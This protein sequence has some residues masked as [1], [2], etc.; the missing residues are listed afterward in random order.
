MHILRELFLY[1]AQTVPGMVYSDAGAATLD[2]Y[3]LAQVLK[4]STADFD[5]QV[6]PVEIV[7]GSFDQYAAVPGKQT[8]KMQLNFAMNAQ[9]GSYSQTAPQWTKVLTGSCNFVGAQTVA[10]T[11]P[12]VF[13]YTPGVA[14]STCGILDHYMGDQAASAAPKKRF[15]NVNGNFKISGQAN[16]VPE[17]QFTLDGSFYGEA[18]STQPDT[19]YA[20][21]RVSPTAFKGATICVGG[22]SALKVSKFEIEA[23]QTIAGR[24][25][26][27]E[28]NGSGYTDI[29]D[30]KIKW[31][32]TAYAATN[33][34]A[35]ILYAITAATEGALT[36]QW[37]PSGHDIQLL[38][39]Y[40]Q[41]TVRKRGDLSGIS[42]FE[43]EG[44]CNRND[45]QIGIGV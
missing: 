15:Y 36:L 6:D 31:K 16:K 34:L 38:S 14:Q 32:V 27:S 11:V 30:R 44:Q 8:G 42:S 28:A 29:T 5:I 26:P 13:V 33:T 43:L 41:F 17:I 19:S 12:G 3:D 39:N 7:A 4:G 18:D 22:L 1:R 35:P 37:G 25:D 45:F 40:A 2:Q 10:G 21:L 23:G 20:K 24:D 9:G